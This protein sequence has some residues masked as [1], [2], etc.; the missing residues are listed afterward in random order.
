VNGII[1]GLDRSPA[2]AAALRWA[3][4]HGAR[5][6][7]TVTGL[8]GWQR[9][10]AGA[11][12]DQLIADAVGRDNDVGHRLSADPLDVALVAAASDADLVV[13]G[14]R[15][16][17]RLPDLLDATPCRALVRRAACPIA[18]VRER[19]LATDAPIVVGLD[20]SGASRQAL[21]W[22]LDDAATSDRQVV[23]VHAWTMPSP[24]DGLPL[25]SDEV[26]RR[27]CAEVHALERMVAGAADE[28]VSIDQ[29][30][31]YGPPVD[32]LCDVAA[33]AS[34]LVVGSCGSGIG[35]RLRFGDVTRGVVD[36]ARSTVVIVPPRW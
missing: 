10:T 15:Q 31:E 20:G 18:V 35:H 22:A 1:V 36:G 6:R 11:D 30:S 2:S 8:L 16:H 28:V 19:A 23:A 33:D 3:V 14:A 27:T 13:V 21:A 5:H 9:D 25:T 24:V 17:H 7:L 34:A 12:I 4:D 29:R 32:V 26:H